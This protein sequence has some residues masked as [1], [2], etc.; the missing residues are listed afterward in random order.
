MARTESLQLASEHLDELRRLLRRHLPDAEVWAYGSRVK[1][2]A[3]EGS[4]L[5]LA[6]RQEGRPVELG[7]LREALTQ[8]GLPMLVELHDWAS[9][10]EAFRQ[11]IRQRHVV[12]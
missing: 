11:E 9:L 12:L 2:Q 7:P 3:H 1:G 6:V 10:P 8:S 4:D 5:D